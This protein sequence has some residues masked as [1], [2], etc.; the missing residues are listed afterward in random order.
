MNK[1]RIITVL[2]IILGVIAALGLSVALFRYIKE[3]VIGNTLKSGTIRFHY[4]ENGN[5]NGIN[6]E[7]GESVLDADGKV[8]NQYFEFTI[9][10]DLMNKDLTYE[11]VVEPT[12]DTNIN[13]DGIKFY[14]TQVVNDSEV[15]ISQSINNSNKVKTL[16]EYSDTDI[17]GQ[18]GKAVYIERIPANTTNYLK[19]FRARMWISE[20][21][22]T[23]STGYFGRTGAFRV[24]VYTNDGLM[25]DAINLTYSS[26]INEETGLPYTTC[27]NVECALDELY[28]LTDTD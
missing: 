3:G 7:D 24:N 15:E 11:V 19:T 8:L 6:I 9:D 13:L 16:S 26:K 20:D 28:D 4:Q 14:L 17:T 2:M 25:L 27:T 5:G 18:T 1:K 23:M 12:S 22:D 21:V 10:G